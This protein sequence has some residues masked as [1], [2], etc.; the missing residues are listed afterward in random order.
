MLRKILAVALVVGFSGLVQADEPAKKYRLS[1][2]GEQTLSQFGL[3]DLQPV[4][5]QQAAKVRGTGGSAAT[6]GQSFLSGMLIDGNT[7]SYVFG[8]DTNGGFA[9]LTQGGL[10]SHVDP[11]HVQESNLGLSLDI[12]NSFRGLLIG[13]AGGTATSLFR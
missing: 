13:G 1:G 3:S 2:K 10:V 7:K 6:R 12:T 11:F 5:K 8:V 9:T 4:A